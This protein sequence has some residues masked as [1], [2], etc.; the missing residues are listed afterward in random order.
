[1]FIYLHDI[2]YNQIA[3]EYQN[4]PITDVGNEQKVLILLRYQTKSKHLVETVNI[5]SVKHRVIS[6][7]E[8]VGLN[9]IQEKKIGKM[10]YILIE[11]K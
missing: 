2:T 3:A 9:Q 6:E 1:M 4:V 5:V 8:Q 11:L 7:L 10:L